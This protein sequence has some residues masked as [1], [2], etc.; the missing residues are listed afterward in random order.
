MTFAIKHLGFYCFI[1]TMTRTD[2][3]SKYEISQPYL[4]TFLISRT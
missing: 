2:D 3:D 4:F 1:K